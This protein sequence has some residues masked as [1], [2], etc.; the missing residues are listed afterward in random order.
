MSSLEMRTLLSKRPSAG[1]SEIIPESLLLQPRGRKP[2]AKSD[3]LG[4]RAQAA[5]VAAPPAEPSTQISASSEATPA[6]KADH[7]ARAEA[8]RALASHKA[9]MQCVY[10]HYSA[11]S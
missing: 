4:G 7:M 11:R 2:V 3:A 8:V 6:T 5:A 10:P 9:L 1:M